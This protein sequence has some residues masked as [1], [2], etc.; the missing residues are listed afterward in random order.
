ML[1]WEMCRM[2]ISH[3]FR[4]PES[5]VIYKYNKAAECTNKYIK[6]HSCNRGYYIIRT[7]KKPS[8]LIQTDVFLT[9]PIFFMYPFS[10]QRT[11]KLYFQD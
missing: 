10:G 4:R 1:L 5:G 7:C 11:L 6:I 8:K 9:Q 2:I 3:E